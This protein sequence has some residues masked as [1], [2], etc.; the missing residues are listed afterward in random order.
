MEGMDVL[1]AMEV[2]KPSDDSARRS[3]VFLL[4][5]EAIGLLQRLKSHKAKKMR[6]RVFIRLIMQVY[7]NEKMVIH[8][9]GSEDNKQKKKILI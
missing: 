2:L 7:I 4:H 1:R 3:C 9:F 6:I 8:F 5:N